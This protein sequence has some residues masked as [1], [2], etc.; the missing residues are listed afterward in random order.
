MKIT[1]CGSIAFYSEMEKVKDELEE[2]GHEVKIP[3]LADKAPSEF[4]GDKKVYFGQHIEENGGI[5]AFPAGHEI[6]NLKERAIVDH[7]KKLEWC[8][9]ILITNY[10]KKGVE[11][12]VG[13]NTLIEIGVGFYLKKPIYI[14]N[15]VSSELSYKVEILGMKPMMLNGDLKKIDKEP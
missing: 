4:G 9:A 15:S 6:W 2:L 8:D 12:Y 11:G 10:E 3:E 13:G 1:V 5:N 7:F 14:L